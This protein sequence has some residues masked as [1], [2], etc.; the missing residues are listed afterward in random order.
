MNILVT[1]GAGYVGSQSVLHFQSLGW[2]VVT[3]DDL[4]TGRAHFGRLADRFV[5]A[6][7]LDTAHLTALLRE[8]A[9]DG[10]LH[11][12]GRAHVP[13]SFQRPLLYFRINVAATASVAEAAVAAGGIPVVFS[14]SCSIYG[15]PPSLPVT[16]ATPPGP[17]SPYGF[18]KLAAERALTACD[19]AHGLRTVCLR[20]FNAAGADPQHRVGETDDGRSRLIPN[21]I[22][23]GLAG[24]RFTVFGTDCDTRDGTCQRDFV[25]TLDL[26]RAHA[27]AFEYLAAGGETTT[28]NLGTGAGATVRELLDAAAAALDVDIEALEGPSRIGDPESLR[29]DAARAREIL[30]WTPQHS[31]LDTIISTAVSWHRIVDGSGDPC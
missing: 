29:A 6:D 5:E 15:N 10:I 23:A 2:R 24:G 11:C 14:S 9:I 18:T 13:E 17:I 21:I 31:D 1:G 16:E 30:G 27:M 26:A 8:E 19:H 7:I 12:A 4:S 28:L 20:Y 3:I 22:R 25:H